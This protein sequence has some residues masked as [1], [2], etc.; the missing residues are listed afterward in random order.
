MRRRRLASELRRLRTESGL[1]MQE[2]ADRLGFAAAS[3]SRIETGRRG[4]R[5][6]DLKAFLDLYNVPEED[7]E[8]LAVLA[9]EAQQRGWW[10]NYGD[11]L[12]SEYATLIGL[13]AEATSVR[14]YQQTLVPGLLQTAGYARAVVEASRPNDTPDEVDRRVAVRMERQKR[15]MDGSP[16]ELSVILGEGVVHQHVGTAQTTAEQFR[17][18]AEANRRPNIMVQVLPYRAGAHPAI[19]GSFNIVGFPAHSDLDVIY[20]ENMASGLYLEDATDVRRYVGVFDYLRAVALSP[21]DSMAMLMDASTN[22]T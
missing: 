14:T 2:V 20:L 7:R 3:I 6:R 5:P 9:R 4:L 18:L 8:A 1:T 17:H 22:L 10:Q 13:E 16:L 21:A 19:T 11:V 15:L 12:P